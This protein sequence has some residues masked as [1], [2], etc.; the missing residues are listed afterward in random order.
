MPRTA[1]LHTPIR[2]R[3]LLPPPARRGGSTRILAAF[4][5]IAAGESTDA[6]AAIGTINGERNTMTGSTRTTSTTALAVAI[7]AAI[8]AA[9][10]AY[11]AS[12]KPSSVQKTA[13]N[14]PDFNKL[15]AP[16][17]H[18]SFIVSFQKGSAKPS[19][20]ALRPEAR[21]RGRVLASRS[22]Q[23]RQGTGARSS[24]EPRLDKAEAKALPS[25]F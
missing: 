17:S 2:S 12:K 1:D 23:A 22:R 24:R 9:P 11:S 5:D 4:C 10:I 18:A 20:S 14:A 7:A 21:R 8:F 3:T 15:A 16:T 19:A 13:R 25:S 6:V